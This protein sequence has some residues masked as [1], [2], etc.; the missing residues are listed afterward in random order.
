METSK[1]SLMLK[2]NE[3]RI[4]EGLGGEPSRGSDG[5]FSRGS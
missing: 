5:E 4:G 1:P 2:E 3:D